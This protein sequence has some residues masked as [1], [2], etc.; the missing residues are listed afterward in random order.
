MFVNELGPLNE[1]FRDKTAA[2]PVAAGLT[3][4]AD[5][6][7]EGVARRAAMAKALEL[8]NY[9]FNA[10]GV[11]LNQRCISGAVMPDPQAGDEVWKRDPQLYLQATTRPGAKIPHAWLIGADSLLQLHTWHRWRELFDANRDVLDDPDA[12]HAGQVL[13][14]P[15]A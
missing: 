6:G 14:L 3:K 7:P 9:E 10:Q 11:E 15:A 1:C 8:K 13:Q 4:L 2:D 5:P 12:L